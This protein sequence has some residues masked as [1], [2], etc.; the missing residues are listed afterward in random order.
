M[1]CAGAWFMPSRAMRRALRAA[2]CSARLAFPGDARVIVKKTRVSSG[3]GGWILALK[4]TPAKTGQ[5]AKST[6]PDMR[7]KKRNA[8]RYTLRG[9]M[10]R[11][12]RHQNYQNF[13]TDSRDPGTPQRPSSLAFQA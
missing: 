9:I 11:V 10:S 13:I 2:G 6:L 5:V 4:H 8:A 7:P 12:G 1:L 3:G